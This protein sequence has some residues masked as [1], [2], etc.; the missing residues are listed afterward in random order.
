MSRRS[1]G[2]PHH[3]AITAAARLAAFFQNAETTCTNNPGRCPGLVCDAPSGH[4][5]IRVCCK[6]PGCPQCR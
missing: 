4:G 2:T 6:L 1:E 3:P 5:A